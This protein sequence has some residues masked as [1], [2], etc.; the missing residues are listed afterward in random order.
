MSFMKWF[1]KIPWFL[2]LLTGCCIL[3]AYPLYYRHYF[4]AQTLIG[5]QS[6]YWLRV[7]LD[8]PFSHVWSF[9][10]SF[11]PLLLSKVLPSL[12]GLLSLTLLY[13]SFEKVTLWKRVLLC[14]FF[15]TVPSF[16]YVFSTSSPYVLMVLLFLLA[17]YLWSRD[18]M[19]SALTLVALLPLFYPSFFLL[20]VVFAVAFLYLGKLDFRSGLFVLFLSSVLLGIFHGF[21]WLTSLQ[22]VTFSHISLSFTDLGGSFGF[23]F[24]L[25]F[26]ALIGMYHLW[27]QRLF[28][29]W[30]SIFVFL[31]MLA[32]T[33]YPLLLIFL[34]FFVVALA[35]V[36]SELILSYRWS[37]SYLKFW[38]ILLVMCGLFFTLLSFT[39]SFVSSEP[40]FTTYK[41]MLYLQS[42]EPGVVFALP[43]YKDFIFY[44]G[45]TPLSSLSRDEY[46]FIAYRLWYG[47]QFSEVRDLL[48]EKQIDYI[49]I[50]DHTR[51]VLWHDDL[52]GLQFHLAH[53]S[54][55]TLAY[56]KHD[57]HIW[58]VQ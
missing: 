3:L 19:Y 54:L 28:F 48:Y 30:I 32:S 20:L 57:L 7:A 1:A 37:S 26:L 47:T 10:L 51:R 50:N 58:R 38:S 6:Y 24:F 56:E 39:T 25:F 22:Y 16:L 18:F 29:V 44:S 42:V 23:G 2:V 49:W 5:G 31:W 53:S 46:N 45:H 41:G 52:A 4:V 14:F 34:S 8:S 9:L 35:V 43:E 15:I 55:F 33:V 36:G 40:S 17:C 21:S 27:Y 11:D 13:T 12:F